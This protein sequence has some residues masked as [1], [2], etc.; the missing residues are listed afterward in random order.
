LKPAEDG[1]SLILRAYEPAGAR[2]AVRITLPE[3]WSLG[4]EVNLLEETLG[5]AELGFLPFKLR[6]WRIEPSG[7]R[8]R[9]VV[10]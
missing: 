1:H 5:P 2:G 4:E 7:R 3:G 8:S 9:G 10:G 6:S